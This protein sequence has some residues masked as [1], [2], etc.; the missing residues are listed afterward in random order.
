MLDG[1]VGAAVL[2]L[3]PVKRMTRARRLQRLYADAGIRTR[4]RDLRGVNGR[5][6][7]RRYLWRTAK[8]D[9]PHPAPWKIARRIR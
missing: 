5:Q 6:L 2:V 3:G 9:R 4:V 1:A 7:R 8:F